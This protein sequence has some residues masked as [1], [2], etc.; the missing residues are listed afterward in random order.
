M[1][2][3]RALRLEVEHEE[4]HV[5]RRAKLLA[6]RAGPGGDD[7]QPVVAGEPA[8]EAR[9]LAFELGAGPVSRTVAFS[10]K[11][12][13]LS[14]S[15]RAISVPGTISSVGRSL[16]ATP[17][18]ATPSRA[19]SAAQTARTARGRPV[20]SRDNRLIWRLYPRLPP[21]IRVTDCTPGGPASGL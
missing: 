20:A 16:S 18:P 15:Q 3:S 13:S 8:G 17:I 11:C 5:G 4:G 2:S 19:T 10:P 7:D 21:A 1:S 14:A 9:P 12:P 6:S